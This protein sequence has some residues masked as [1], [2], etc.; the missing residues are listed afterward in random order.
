MRPTILTYGVAAAVTD[1]Y[2]ESQTPAAG[3][4]Q[5][6]TLTAT[7]TNTYQQHVSVSCAGSDAARSFA[8]VGTD[9][10][11]NALTETLAGSDEDITIGAKNFKSVTSITVDDDTAGAVTAGMAA[12]GESQ[13]VPT[14]WR[15]DNLAITFEVVSGTPSYDLQVTNDDVQSTTYAVESGAQ[16]YSL[17]S[18]A[19]TTDYAGSL[20]QPFLATRLALTA[21]GVVKMTI[22][23]V[24]VG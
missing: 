13:W 24:Q 21:V 19:K 5:A 4:A 22:T 20:M 8:F 16:A 23:Q 17:F 1:K 12:A 11:G 7:L 14:N 3:G 18:Q 9:W 2:A 15:G 6:L 10:Q